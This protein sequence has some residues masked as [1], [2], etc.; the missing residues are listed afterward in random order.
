MEQSD[1]SKHKESELRKP[2]QYQEFILWS[3]LPT[4][5][6]IRLGLEWQKDFAAHYHL[7]ERTLSVWKQRSD[8]K[9]RVRK[10]MKM[11]AFDRTPDVI[12]GIYRSA[13]KGNS[14]S[15]RIWLKYFEGWVEE[16]K[17]D[18]TLKVE[19]SSNDIRFLIEG[20]PEKEK[21]ECYGYL[22]NILDISQSL[23]NSGRLA[24]GTAS[25]DIDEA[26]ICEDSDNDAQDVPDTK[27]CAVS[28]RHPSSLRP[29]L[30]REVFQGDY[31][32]AARWW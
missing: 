11:W 32:G 27:T 25:Y 20:M 13:L 26:V 17:V 6:K 22:R 16:T 19:I 8:F 10:I 21:L 14:D 23:H 24:D 29:D 2:T 9:D 18:H 12:L 15:Q 3:A 5:E 30:E 28:A 1:T 7:Q 4:P 31:K